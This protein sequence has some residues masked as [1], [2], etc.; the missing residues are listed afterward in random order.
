VLGFKVRA[1]ISNGTRQ[2]PYFQPAN[3][4]I[5]NKIK[6]VQMQI[7]SKIIEEENMNCIKLQ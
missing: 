3:G 4:I 2:I 5:Q 7:K 6:I 1:P